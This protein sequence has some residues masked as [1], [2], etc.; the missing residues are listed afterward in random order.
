[1]KAIK[2]GNMFRS[3]L[4]SGKFAYGVIT[5]DLKD[6]V[7]VNIYDFIGDADTFDEARQAPIIYYD[8]LT[9]TSQFSKRGWLISKEVD[10]SEKSKL[11][12]PFLTMGRPPD[13]SLIR[14][15]DPDFKEKFLP[16]DAE[17]IFKDR[18]YN[19]A[20]CLFPEGNEL[21]IE[22]LLYFGNNDIPGKRLAHMAPDEI[23]NFYTDYKKKMAG[24][25]RENFHERWG[26]RLDEVQRKP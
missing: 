6:T 1:M 5:Y 2:I 22:E 23:N 13:L 9:T 20:R 24:S 26:S 18:K 8:L 19:R 25:Q 12:S 10:Q 11:K 17:T 3:P 16:E 7:L 21:F 14:V 15:N 4:K